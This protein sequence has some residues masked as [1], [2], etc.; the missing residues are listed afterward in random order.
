METVFAVIIAL[1]FYSLLFMLLNVRAT[2]KYR[3][4]LKKRDDK[5]NTLLNIS[6]KQDGVILSQTKTIDHW[7]SKYFVENEYRT[8]GENDWL[9]IKD[10]VSVKDVINL[11]KLPKNFG[12]NHISEVLNA[13]YRKFGK[14]VLLRWGRVDVFEEDG[15]A[16]IQLTLH[17]EIY[18]GKIKDSKGE[19]F[20]K[21]DVYDSSRIALAIRKLADRQTV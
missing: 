14:E 20:S 11:N 7:K 10:E 21:K 6:K 15:K 8:S 16:W 5:I 3:E 12:A 2:N 17:N 18:E 13:Q 4:D 1:I 19:S 9:K